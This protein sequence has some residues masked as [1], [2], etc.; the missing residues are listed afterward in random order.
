MWLFPVAADRARLPLNET[1]SGLGGGAE[2]CSQWH[3]CQGDKV[4]ECFVVPAWN[5]AK[6]SSHITLQA[7]CIPLLQCDGRTVV[8][9]RRRC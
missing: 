5:V 3:P 6:Y 9:R 4:T 2:F 8:F 1:T 7:V